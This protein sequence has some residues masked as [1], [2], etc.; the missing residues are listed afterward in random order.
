ML[1]QCTTWLYA[2]IFPFNTIVIFPGE[3]WYSQNEDEKGTTISEI[4]HMLTILKWEVLGRFDDRPMNLEM[5][6]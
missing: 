4:S 1:K 6:N 2:C 5:C 3:K